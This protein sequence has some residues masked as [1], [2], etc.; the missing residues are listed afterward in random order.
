MKSL[1]AIVFCLGLGAAALTSCDDGDTKPT[2]NVDATVPSG[3]GGAGGTAADAGTPG[4]GG[5]VGADSG[6]DAGVTSD[7]PAADTGGGG[8]DKA[9]H[10]A[11]INAA[12]AAGVSELEVPGP[13]A[14]DYATCSQ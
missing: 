11:I 4:T 1:A 12:P 14:P 13:A 3:G 5:S 2:S 6:A 8:D 7:A 9:A 10:L